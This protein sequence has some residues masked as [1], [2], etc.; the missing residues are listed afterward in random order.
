[1]KSN[2]T[3]KKQTE[4]KI[5]EH[6]S[7]L[8]VSIKQTN[9]TAYLNFLISRNSW[10]L[11][12]PFSMVVLFVLPVL[13]VEFL[14][15]IELSSD[16]AKIIIDQRV[17]NIAVIISITMVI[18]GFLINNLAIKDAYVYSLLFKHSFLYPIIFFILSVIGCMFL[19]SLMRD[20]MSL[21]SMRYFANVTIAATY[22]AIMILGLIGFLFTKIVNFTDREKINKL[23]EKELLKEIESTIYTTLIQ[24]YSRAI[25][26]IFMKKK[27]VSRIFSHG[28]PIYFGEKK[29]NEEFE[30]ADIDLPILDRLTTTKI[31]ELVE[32]YNLRYYLV[33]LNEK[34]SITN[35]SY[36]E[37]EEDKISRKT[38]SILKSALKK[39]K[40]RGVIQK[41][42]TLAY[43]KKKF[44]LAVN[45]NNQEDINEILS[46]YKKVSNIEMKN[47]NTDIYE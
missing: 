1:M 33:G 14:N 25:F 35:N 27:N 36:F 5:K 41:N 12:V 46:M 21:N 4:E 31:S 2:E 30:I 16:S 29:I 8:L 3:L 7:E 37:I 40:A 38:N 15:L 6:H 13:D 45:K 11:I 32:Y 42:D 10:I 47:L 9:T 17:A 18:V 24:K 28:S 44:S 19:I 39:K 26:D 20:I 22:L 23:V 43:L 34:L